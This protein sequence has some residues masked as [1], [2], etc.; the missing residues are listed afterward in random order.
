MKCVDCHGSG[1]IHPSAAAVRAWE[2]D[3]MSDPPRS[4][5]C[6]YCDGTG[7]VT[8]ARHRKNQDAKRFVAA[9]TGTNR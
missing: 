8:I 2:A 4:F 3:P 9:L 5:D 6:P 7:K 1:R